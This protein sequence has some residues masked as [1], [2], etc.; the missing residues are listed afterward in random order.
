MYTLDRQKY[1]ELHKI[2][3]GFLVNTRLD[4]AQS[5][6]LGAAVDSG[7]KLGAHQI[8][9]T[10]TLVRLYTRLYVGVYV[11]GYNKIDNFSNIEHW[12]G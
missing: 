10:R 12:Y 11:L 5:W 7:C 9:N 2:I 3:S 6:I 8:S 4:E 1:Q